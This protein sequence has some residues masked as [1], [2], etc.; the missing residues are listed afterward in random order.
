MPDYRTGRKV[1]RK[2]DLGSSRICHPGLTLFMARSVEQ[3]GHPPPAAPRRPK[4]LAL[5][6][7]MRSEVT[8]LTVLTWRACAALGRSNTDGA[9]CRD[10]CRVLAAWRREN[11]TSRRAT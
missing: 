2:D 7:S 10:G 6:L 11:P 3:R 5:E 1:G 9:H 8:Y 4:L